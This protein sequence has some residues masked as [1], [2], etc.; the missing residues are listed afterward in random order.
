[1]KHIALLAVLLCA[2]CD[3]IFQQPHPGEAW[4][5]R[6]RYD[7]FKEPYPQTNHVIAVKGGY[8]LYSFLYN[9]EWRTNSIAQGTFVGAT[10]KVVLKE[11][12]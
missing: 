9:G 8:V 2:G 5:D 1:M 6:R 12:K 7:P 3:R 4:V 11:D 10:R